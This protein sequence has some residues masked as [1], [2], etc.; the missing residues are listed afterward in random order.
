MRRLGDEHS[1]IEQA[2]PEFVITV[3]K[4]LGDKLGLDVDCSD[5][6]TLKI[7][8]LRDGPF[9]WWNLNN[10]L[11]Q[12]QEGDCIIDINGSRGD[13]EALV[14]MMHK[15]T[16]IRA[17]FIRQAAPEVVIIVTKTVGE[18]LGLDVGYS[19]ENTLKIDKVKDGPFSRW[20]LNNPSQ[21]IREGDHI[22]D[23]N[24]SRGDANTLVD[25]MH[26]SATL[27]VTFVRNSNLRGS[28]ARL[29]C[30]GLNVVN[31][32]DTPMLAAGSASAA[33]LALRNAA[34]PRTM[35]QSALS[36]DVSRGK[37]R[38]RPLSAC[39]LEAKI[40]R[41]NERFRKENEVLRR[42]NR[43]LKEH[44]NGPEGAHRRPQDAGRSLLPPESRVVTLE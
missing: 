11:Q 37:S 30:D 5:G 32:A 18:R 9:L 16:T 34:P 1:Q 6:K 7:D 35:E 44:H 31:T 21:Q 39:E 2:A 40:R 3:T 22:I 20:N 38:N 14:D 10:P 25:L 8:R 42:N 13:S 41:R 27:K 43:Q 26:N 17:T 29:S 36:G 28:K 4:S 19:D 12:I 15:S 23:V 24:G 33:C